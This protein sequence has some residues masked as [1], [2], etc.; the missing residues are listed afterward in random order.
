MSSDF[1]T[2]AMQFDIQ[3]IE[4][5]ED[6]ELKL[7]LLIGIYEF[8]FER[9]SSI[10]A[11]ALKPLVMGRDLIAQAPSGT[12]KSS[13]FVIST[14][15]AIDTSFNSCQ[16]LVLTPTREISQQ[17][18]FLLKQIG[19]RVGVLSC[20]FV[21]GTSNHERR[22]ALEAGVQVAVGTPGCVLD[23]ITR[24]VLK[25]DKIELLI[26]DEADEVLARG[27]GE[28]VNLILALLKDNVQLSMF[29][30]SMPKEVTKLAAKFMTD[31]I[32]VL[33][34]NEE[35]IL[36]G[37]R[38]YYV[39]IELEDW[40]FDTLCNLIDAG[41][42]SQMTIYVRTDHRVDLLST[43]MTAH[44]LN[45]VSIHSGMEQTQLNMNLR[46]FRSGCSRLL[47]TTDRMRVGQ[48]GF[49]V[50]YDMPTCFEAYLRRIG[51]SG[52]YGWRGIAI[53]FVH[54]SDS[55]S[56]KEIEKYFLTT[57]RELPQDVSNL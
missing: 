42:Y 37:I 35:M 2:A 54:P 14:L 10:Q 47:V 8:G 57:V 29:A 21:G 16:A 46:D 34:R 18:A 1:E 51:R 11:K 41:D 55:P 44:D 49:K 28:Q 31:P 39:A 50:N 15:Q 48:C 53:N 32:K 9:P 23:M 38:Q 17:I 52:W 13:A 36:E 19:E 6:L 43:M 20:A 40:K 22:A 4:Y 12:G 7:E 56:V 30:S 5:F 24:K 27:F 26:I 25:S 33:V 3:E 45:V